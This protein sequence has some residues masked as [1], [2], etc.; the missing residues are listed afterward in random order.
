MRCKVTGDPSLKI[1][2]EINF[3]SRGYKCYFRNI[4]RVSKNFS[5]VRGLKFLRL[6]CF[7]LGVPVVAHASH[8]TRFIENTKKDNG[9]SKAILMKCNNIFQMIAMSFTKE[10]I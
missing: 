10:V 7:F 1:L 3:Q 6:F 9:V 5:F 4:C 8:F 2:S